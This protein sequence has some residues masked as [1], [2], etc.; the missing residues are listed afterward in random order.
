MLTTT[1]T[2]FRRDIK[3]Y[4]DNVINNLET[5]IIN[6]GK[7]NGVVIISLAEYNSM[8]AA[9]R[10]L[11]SK[12]NEVKVNSNIDNLESDSLNNKK[13]M[14]IEFKELLEKLRTKSKDAPSLEEITKEVE[15]VRNA[16][17]EK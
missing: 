14:K 9:Q 15:S 12:D 6:R 16:R 7:D 13:N 11:N 17:Y 10:E 8:K 1:V 3:G 5:L 2:D 4:F